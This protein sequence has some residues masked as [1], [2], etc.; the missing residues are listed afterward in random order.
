MASA[1]PLWQS[2]TQHLATINPSLRFPLAVIPFGLLGPALG[3]Q[4]LGLTL[5]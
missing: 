2:L 3:A 5:D 1:S 4:T